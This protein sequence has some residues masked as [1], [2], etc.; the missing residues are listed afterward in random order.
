MEGTHKMKSLRRGMC[1]FFISCFLLSTIISPLTFSVLSENKQQLIDEL[2]DVYLLAADDQNQSCKTN[3]SPNVDIEYISYKKIDNK[4]VTVSLKV[5]SNGTIENS[6][7]FKNDNT[8]TSSNFNK[9]IVYYVINIETNENCYIL[10]YTNNTCKINDKTCSNYAIN[11]SFLNISFP[12][13]SRNES[14]VSMTGRSYK[15]KYETMNISKI[16]SD[17]VP[18]E[19]IFTASICASKTTVGRGEIIHFTANI[20]DNIGVTKPAYT[21]SWDIGY[22]L[23]KQGLHVNHSYVSSGTYIVR[24]KVSDSS[25]F[26]ETAE[27]KIIVTS[28]DCEC[29]TVTFFRPQNGFYLK[30]IPIATNLL[31]KRFLFGKI[32]IR[33]KP[34]DE[35]SG[36]KYVDFYLDNTKQHRDTTKPYE[37]QWTKR[38]FLPTRYKL[39][40]VASDLYD[41]IDTKTITV[42]RLL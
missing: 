42:Y 29:P 10:N 20:T 7:D 28:D 38:S 33:V 39:K 21:V 19:K 3:S 11:E 32:T 26:I 36:I 6:N 9:T 5:N 23:Q 15:K 1:L 24:L 30:N 35:V 4:N 22:K 40:V 2:D 25:G 41:N 18:N 12:L 14:L 37:W 31:E 17:F 27:C 16:F 8:A 13:E 34:T